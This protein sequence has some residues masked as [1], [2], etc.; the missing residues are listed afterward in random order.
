M[1]ITVT[2]Q[3]ALDD[4][5]AAG[6]ED[7]VVDSP[8]GV[9]VTVRASDSVT[10]HASGSATVT[11]SGS[12]TVTASDSATVTATPKVAVHLHSGRCTIAGGVLIDH[13]IIDLTDPQTWCDYHGV[14]TVNGVATVHKAVDDDWTTGRGTYYRPGAS[15][16]A[17]DWRDDHEC[18]GGLHF[19]PQ[20]WQA[21]EHMP[22]ATRF[23]AVGVAVADL[24]PIL[25]DTP[26]CKTPR[27]VSPCVEVTIDGTPTNP[28]S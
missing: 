6:H 8:R 21:R 2:T 10:V 3:Q 4:A 7:I 23:V 19:S 26:K 20:P 13:T 12:A 16:S 5:I 14:P 28:E 25:G 22:N 18:G 1:D 17:P 15:P 24:R 11:A 9:W 27:V